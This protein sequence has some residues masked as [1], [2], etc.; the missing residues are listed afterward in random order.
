MS[1]ALEIAFGS[2]DYTRSLVLESVLSTTMKDFLIE[3]EKNKTPQEIKMAF[4]QVIDNMK[5]LSKSM[6]KQYPIYQNVKKTESIDPH[7]RLDF[8]NEERLLNE[9]YSLL[10]EGDESTTKNVEDAVED[11]D[12]MKAAQETGRT[13]GEKDVTLVVKKLRDLG[14]DPTQSKGKIAIQLLGK[15][16]NKI[17]NFFASLGSGIKSTVSGLVG[18]AKPK[19]KAAVVSGFVGNILQFLKKKWFSLFLD[20][21]VKEVGTATVFE[22]ASVLIDKA[23]SIL[24]ENYAKPS[25]EEAQKL[26]MMSETFF[27]A[28]VELIE[29]IYDA[30]S[31]MEGNDN[32]TKSLKEISNKKIDSMVNMHFVPSKYTMEK[33][34]KYSDKIK[35]KLKESEEKDINELDLKSIG[36][37]IRR[38][39]NTLTTWMS[40]PITDGS[41]SAQKIAPLFKGAD[42]TKALKA[43][44]NKMSFKT[45]DLFIKE[46][47]PL[48][49]GLKKLPSGG[50]AAPSGGGAAPSGGGAAP[51]GGGAA[52]SGGGAAE[53]S[54]KKT[55][56][57]KK[58]LQD[59]GIGDEEQSKERAKKI[60][61]SI[62][63]SFDELNIALD[64]EKDIKDKISKTILD[65]IIT[66]V[67]ANAQKEIDEKIVIERWL[68]LSGI[69]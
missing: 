2:R 26:F 21:E 24:V 66:P 4:K 44:L 13:L 32:P 20:K 43:D 28:F 27:S 30:V 33:L 65:D 47:K 41:G 16:K 52:P 25:T 67:I 46:N 31:E 15:G 60:K 38:G 1:A 12:V 22:D 54:S 37:S 7:D 64:V 61:S 53:A 62:K 6:K 36:G 50:G 3:A 11:T 29:G 51:S 45:L 18:K 35:S 23:I 5:L 69:L 63:K 57:L 58:I 17:S 56:N 48:L 9:Y 39:F 40:K 42:I 49:S 59:A 19:E 8:L 55:I 14:I 34:K 10:F 68:K